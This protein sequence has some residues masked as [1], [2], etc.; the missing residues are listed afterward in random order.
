VKETTDKSMWGKVDRIGKGTKATYDPEKK[1]ITFAFNRGPD[2]TSEQLRVARE[3]LM[4]ELKELGYASKMKYNGE[5]LVENIEEECLTL[6]KKNHQLVIHIKSKT[7]VEKEREK[8]KESQK[9]P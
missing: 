2:T 5:V 7:E 4:K 9:E 6:T 3:Q 1:I 8:E